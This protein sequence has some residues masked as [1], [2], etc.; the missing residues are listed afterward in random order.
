MK[1]T[2]DTEKDICKV[3]GKT[4]NV[5][6]KE[7]NKEIAISYL[8]RFLTKNT[9]LS[10]YEN[11]CMWMSYRYCVGRHTIAAHAHAGDI[12]TQCYGRMSD[13]RSIFTAYDINR[14]IEESLR[15]SSGVD[16]RFP[17]TSLNKIYTTAVDIWCQFIED[18][19]ITS[20][21]EYLRYKSV[22]IILT[23]NER[24]Y[25]IETTTWDE[26]IDA[27]RKKISEKYSLKKDI[28]DKEL[29]EYKQYSDVEYYLNTIERRPTENYFFLMN[30]EDLFVWNN[31][32]HLFDLEHHHKSILN[33]GTE[34]E[35]YWTYIEGSEKKE[36]GYYYKKDFKYDRVRVPVYSRI[37]SS[38]T[39]IPDE[40]IK[41][42][43]Y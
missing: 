11:D 37:S 41:E 18:Y 31:L 23:D 40:S 33:D 4:F 30:V 2:F 43:L 16:F 1:I 6:C 17:V 28:T 7:F 13:E 3:G 35:W 42:D 36:D 8:R 10:E 19:N 26:W 38:I 9:K 34:C 25:K 5:D 21:E 27:N 12:A 15:W 29:N 39:Y 14:E 20:K 22:D 32:C 24:G